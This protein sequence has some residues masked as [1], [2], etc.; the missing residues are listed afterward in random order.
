[1]LRPRPGDR[2]W[3]DDSSRSYG[4]TP[5]LVVALL[6][7]ILFAI[8]SL[9]HGFQVL[10]YRTWYFIPVLIG[11]LMEVVGY[12]F[13]ILSNRESP[14]PPLCLNYPAKLFSLGR[15]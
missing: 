15:T 5:S 4:Y 9:C 2:R 1:M 11:T 13:R 14:N 12:C 7:V 3:T 6:G 10:K 8:A